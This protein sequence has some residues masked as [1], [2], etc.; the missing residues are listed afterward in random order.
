M[1]QVA[2][3]ASSPGERWRVGIGNW[4][5]EALVGRCLFSSSTSPPNFASTCITLLLMLMLLSQGKQVILVAKVEDY[6]PEQNMATVQTS[7]AMTCHV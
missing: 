2:R 7:D 4:V 3:P 6:D 5:T 1:G